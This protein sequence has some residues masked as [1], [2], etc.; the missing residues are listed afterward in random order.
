MRRYSGSAGAG[1]YMGV[2]VGVVVHIFIGFGLLFGLNQDFQKAV[3]GP[4]EVVE[5]EELEPEVEEPPPP[6]PDLKEPPPPF[7]PPP[8]I[9]LDVRPTSSETAIQTTTT[10]VPDTGPTIDPRR[11]PTKPKYPAASQR[12]G[13]EGR[14]VLLVFINPDGS[15]GE[16]QIKTSS[17]FPRLDQAA[18]QWARSQRWVPA[19]KNGQPVGGWKEQPVVFRLTDG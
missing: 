11:P 6:P 19:L 3:L 18:V 5:V 16:V 4:V 10:T 14:V 1:P 8:E 12:L 13:E 7:L 9:Q 2:I 15:V 17:G